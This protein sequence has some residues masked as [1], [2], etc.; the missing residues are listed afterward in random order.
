MAAAKW[1]SHAKADLKDIAAFIAERDS[2]RQTARKVAREIRNKC[3]EYAE[4]VATGSVIGTRAPHL[5]ED[6]RTFTCKRW[7]V[8]FRPAGDGI[9]V[10]RVF[11]AARDYPT[12][13][14]D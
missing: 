6:Y 8:V 5:G 9:L 14:H 2:R 3:D 4:A 11:D 10:L 13:F 12:L 1:T 7:V